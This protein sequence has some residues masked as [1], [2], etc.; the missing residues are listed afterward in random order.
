MTSHLR[1]RHLGISPSSLTFYDPLL[2]G[3][4]QLSSISPI[5]SSQATCQ[6]LL[7]PARPLGNKSFLQKDQPLP[8]P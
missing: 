3:N 8:S 6:T 5:S 4:L 1:V 7:Q 2:P